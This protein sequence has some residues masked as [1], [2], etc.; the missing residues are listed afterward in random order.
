MSGLFRHGDGIGFL[1]GFGAGPLSF[2]LLVLRFLLGWVRLHLLWWEGGDGLWVRRM[3][4]V[5]RSRRMVSGVGTRSSPWVRI[6]VWL[7]GGRRFWLGLGGRLGFGRR[8]IV[9]CGSRRRRFLLRVGMRSRFVRRRSVRSG[10]G[11]IGRRLLAG[12][13]GFG[14]SGRLSGLGTGWGLSVRSLS[15][16]GICRLSIFRRCW[17]IFWRFV[18]GGFGLRGVARI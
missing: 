9:R 4:G 12:M 3:V 1:V 5:M 17:S 18:A 8:L 2:P 6:C 15:R 14:I 13:R 11:L 10:L 16:I 7:M